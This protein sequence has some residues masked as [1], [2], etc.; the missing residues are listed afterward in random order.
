MERERTLTW[1]EFDGEGC[2][3][4]EDWVANGEARCIFVALEGS[5]AAFELDNLTD[6]LVPTDFDQLIHL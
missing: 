5:S 3:G 6:E 4:S 2:L 1:T